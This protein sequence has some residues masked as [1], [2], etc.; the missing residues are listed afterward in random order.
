[1]D[2]RILIVEDDEN[3]RETMEL[4]LS[5]NGYTVFTCDTGKDIFGT[6]E[7]TAPDL[8]L[9][10]VLLGDMDGRDICKAVKTHPKTEHIPVIIVSSVYN[11]FNIILDEK[12]NDVIPK[13]FTED[14]LLSRVQRQ[15]SK[16][17]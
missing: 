1:M 11:I 14:I 4:L 15:L 5:H 16:A 8:I 6:V 7:K 17:S 2:K 13:P 10:D 9:L 3:V 12:A